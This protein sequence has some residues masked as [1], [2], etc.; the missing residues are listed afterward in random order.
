MI[1]VIYQDGFWTRGGKIVW[2]PDS[3]PKFWSWLLICCI[4]REA[5]NVT[6]DKFANNKIIFFWNNLDENLN[7]SLI[8]IRSWWAVALRIREDRRVKQKK[9]MHTKQASLDL[10]GYPWKELHVNPQ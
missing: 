9:S 2:S 7:Q 10:K 6:K 5:V 8:L 3:L 4:F 1:K